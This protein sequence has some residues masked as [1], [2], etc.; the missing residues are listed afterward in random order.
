ME[1]TARVGLIVY[2]Y[3]NRD[4]RKITKL[5]DCHYHS[6]RLRYLVLYVDLDEVDEIIS[7]LKGQRFVKKVLISEFN[8]IDQDFVGSL[9]RNEESQV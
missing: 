2:L 1:K 7:Y 3:Y 9:H 6:K 8:Q 5:G 4:A